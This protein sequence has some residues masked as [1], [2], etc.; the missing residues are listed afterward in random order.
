M[1]RRGAPGR[2]PSET[3]RRIYAVVARI[4]RGRVA[5]YGQVAA[6]AGRGRH[7]RQVG[8]ALHTLP[9]G[10]VLPWQRVIN[11]RGEVSE[12][13][14]PG[15]AGYQRH[16]LEEEGV[17][18]DRRGRVDLARFGWDP[19]RA[20]RLDERREVAAVEAALRPLGNAARA[21][22]AKAYLK[23]EL[24]FLGLDTP[25]LRRAAREWDQQH[26]DLD[27]D[28]L[29]RLATALWGTPLFELRAFAVEVLVRRRAALFARPRSRRPLLDFLEILLRRSRTWAF[30]DWIATQ[31]VAPLMEADRRLLSRL[32][33]WMQDS[34]F[35]IRR[36][37][38]LALL[39]ALRRGDGDWARFT[40]Y[41][42]SQLGDREFFIRKAIGW[43]LR[44]VG[45]R[46]PRLVVRFLAPRLD[47]V[48]GLTL[49]EAVKYL[50]APDRRRLRMGP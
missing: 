8:Y 16:L 43:V 33:A 50:P 42:D 28:D 49:R 13:A 35:W 4:P 38:L 1:G 29:L 18:F 31:L 15:W 34:D 14:T 21:A 10:T 7:A 25:A 26:A 48:A 27:V 47:R 44:E 46:R 39:P 32:D 40:R 3:Y 12:R 2:A 22:G 37:A 6:L 9:D 20:A 36:A 30:V 5:T 24:T 19:D 41:A 17:R 23:S 45:K 11:A